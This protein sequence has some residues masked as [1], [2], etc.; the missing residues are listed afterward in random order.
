MALTTRRVVMDGVTDAN[1]TP[2]AEMYFDLPVNLYDAAGNL[3]RAKGPIV[4]RLTQ[5]AGQIDL[6]VNDEGQQTGWAYRV[7][8]PSRPRAIKGL[9][10]VPTGDGSEMKFVEHFLPDA[11]PHLIP[12]YVPLLVLGA[13][14]PI[15]DGIPT[16]TVVARI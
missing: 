3:V 11:E 14:D 7:Q 1:G 2:V 13:D 10:S 5:G 9:L 6:P 4:A 8:I 16:P 12:T 15:P